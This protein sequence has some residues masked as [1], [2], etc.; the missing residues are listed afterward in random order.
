MPPRSGARP[1]FLKAICGVVFTALVIGTY[2]YFHDVL[3]HHKFRSVSFGKITS[4]EGSSTDT[5]ES[6][7]EAAAAGVEESSST[8]PFVQGGEALALRGE[9]DSRS[10]NSS[11]S[12]TNPKLYS[13]YENALHQSGIS[14]GEFKS[15]KKQPFRSLKHAIKVEGGLLKGL[16]LC[17]SDVVNNVTSKSQPNGKACDEE[18]GDSFIKNWQRNGVKGLCEAIAP[19]KIQ[20]FDSTSNI[21]A[22]FCSFENAMMSFKRMRRRVREG[23]AV[24]RQWERGF[25]SA[26]CGDT[27]S[28]DLGQYL[29]IY[30]PDIQYHDEAI[31]DYVFNETVLAYS[32]KNI[33]NLGYT[34]SDFF[35][36]WAT[37][38]LSGLSQSTRDV[39]FLNI[40]S[41]RQGVCYD[42]QPNQYFKH[43][44]LTFRRIVKAVDFGQ[45][46]NV[47]FK[48][49][50]L[51]PR[52]HI[53]FIKE[54]W[55]EDKP[56]SFK[57]PSSLFQ[58]WNLQIRQNY[59]LLRE[60]AMPTNWKKQILF[61]IRPQKIGSTEKEHANTV[62][63]TSNVKELEEGLKREYESDTVVFQDLSLLSFEKQIQLIAESSIV[64]GMHGGAV[65]LALH[66]AIGTKFCCGVIEIFP[67]SADFGSIR[68]Y[69]NALRRA[70]VSYSRLELE[71]AVSV[72]G[73][74][75][76]SVVPLD[77]LQRELARMMGRI[78]TAPSCL[79][80]VVVKSPFV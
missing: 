44:D 79:L 1:L 64:V 37:L 4:W 62:R 71:P 77:T 69:G 66:M 60:N 45:S 53:P 9:E 33:R 7:N 25:I 76:G 74:G 26:E 34:I 8:K 22:R 65:A 14:W 31:C 35:N 10:V 50:L 17:G 2:L 32:H 72:E 75:G 12:P 28:D 63:D 70:G 39:T 29:Q 21:N 30:K 36:V 40:D 57:G 67:S 41:L 27:A 18:W 54:G 80:P 46:S 68:G 24:G 61:V 59:D 19:S 23:G 58:R 55:K 38:W 6:F 42:D 56:C 52:P 48:R 73:R 3:S 20:C 51:Q 47:C 43:Y 13:N 49:L 5:K 78:R 11:V 16:T 15:R